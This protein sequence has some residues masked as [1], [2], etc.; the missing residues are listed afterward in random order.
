MIDAKEIAAEKERLESFMGEGDDKTA[1]LTHTLQETMWKNVGIIR[2]GKGLTG[3][4]DKINEIHSLSRDAKA[5]DIRGLMRRLELENLLLAGEMVTRA[6]LTRTESRG[7]HFR[8]DYPGEDGKWL[9][10]LFITNKNGTIAIEKRPA[11]G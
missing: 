9:A 3:A 1:S 4:I 10:N 7:A 5:A 2:N 6:A 11:E 8:E